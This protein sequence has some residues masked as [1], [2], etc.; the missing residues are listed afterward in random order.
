V[1]SSQI[2]FVGTES[3]SSSI[4]QIVDQH[5][6]GAEAINGIR[7]PDPT[8]KE[9]NDK[10]LA[11]IASLRG[12]PMFY[13]VLSSGIGRGPFARLSDGSVKLDLINGIGIH[14]MGHSHPE[15]I[16]ASIE[17]SLSDVVMQGHLYAGKEYVELNRRLVRLASQKSRLKHS[18]IT[19]CGSMA[20]ESALKI[21]R[22]KHFPAKNIIAFEKAFAGRTI[23]M[24][25]VTDNKDYKQGQP[26]Y[27]EVFRLPFY[28]KKDPVRSTEKALETLKGHLDKGPNSF[29]TFVFEPMQGEGGYAFGTREFFLPLLETCKKNNIAIWLDEV[30]T[31]C[32]TGNFF[33]FETLGLGDYVDICTVA[34]TA[35]SAATLF[36]DEYNPKPGLIAGTFAGSSA[37]LAAGNKLL[38]ILETKGFMGSSGR[39]QEIHNRF[40]EGF[41]NL[42]ETTCEGM[43]N[44]AG[45]LGLMMAVTPFDGSKEKV[46]AFLK[47]LFE[48]G[49]M[50]FGCGRDP[51]RVRL[52]VP[53]IIQNSE[54]DLALGVFEKTAQQ[55]A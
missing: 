1:P 3:L 37:A 55:L 26:D 23:M 4:E 47:A 15:I 18:W 8:I 19:T 34:K 38:D 5:L 50:S 36:T 51:Y 30:Q 39:V 10:L 45:G 54:I 33:A 17:G 28:D 24:A 43:F 35:Q 12:R 13:P 20:N 29:C 14:I 6:A 2:H 46:N 16:K 53:A 7:P 42:N 49:V 27:N 22:Q 11:E 40:V 41:N 44:N 32:R 25:E 9:S 52:L 31:F 21:A 48:N